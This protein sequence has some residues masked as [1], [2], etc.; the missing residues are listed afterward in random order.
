MLI[1]TL[2]SNFVIL[3]LA[4]APWLLLG[5]LV[6]GLIQ[7]F[8]PASLMS[9]QLGK[10][11]V[12]TAFK[13][14]LIGAPLPLCSCGVIPAALGLRKAGASKSATT[15][16]MVATP[17]T[18]VDSVTMSYALLGPFMAVVRP[19]AAIVSAVVAGSLVGKDTTVDKPP[20]PDEAK[21]DE[22]KPDAAK[23]EAPGKKKSCCS[24]HKPVVKE[25]TTGQR[26]LTSLH[27]S[28]TDLLEGTALW[29]ICGLV[30]AA[31]VQTY[32]PTDFLTQWGGGLMAMVVM[33]L[34]SIPMYICATASTPIAAGLLLSGVSPGAVLVFMMAGPATN[35]ATLG[36]VAK[37]LGRRAVGAYLFGVIGTAMAF[38]W[39]TNYLVA[40]YGFEVTPQIGPE[41]EMLPHWLVMGSGILLALLVLRNL[42]IKF[43]SA[44]VRK[45]LI[46]KMA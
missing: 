40:N 29:L 28:V 32:V 3:F 16:F 6:A 7:L 43:G 34:I 42:F 38:G 19:I 25:Q 13:A 22:A 18:G 8:V 21:P 35:V 37:E 27:Y 14:A 31:A 26:L 39:L 41:H 46:A 4:S 33:V 23:P 5:L 45:V 11:G 15:A 10:E 1:D 44:P 17:E 36:V 20:A 2:L 30:F 9:K 12:G 24:S